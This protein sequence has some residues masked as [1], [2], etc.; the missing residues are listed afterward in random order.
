MFNFFSYHTTNRVAKVF[1]KSTQV[2][3]PGRHG[4]F[5]CV[6]PKKVVILNDGIIA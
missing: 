1:W 3:W 4:I 5:Y 2:A 6:I